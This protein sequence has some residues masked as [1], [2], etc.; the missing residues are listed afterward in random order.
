GTGDADLK[1][2]PAGAPA[3]N[4]FSWCGVD[5]I[6]P[7]VYCWYVKEF[8]FSARPG[9]GFA[10]SSFPIST[11]TAFLTAVLLASDVGEAVAAPGD[12]HWDRSFN[13][14]GTASVNYA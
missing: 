6:N 9:A 11:L 13:M 14:P 12:G 1:S 7:V 5:I 8:F 10:R 3:V 4:K 2:S